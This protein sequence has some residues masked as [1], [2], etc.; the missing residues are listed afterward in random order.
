MRV[1]GLV[2]AAVWGV[3]VISAPAAA[4]EVWDSTYGVVVYEEDVGDVAVWSYDG[5]PDHPGGAIFIDG[6]AG[7]FV[8]RGEYGGFWMADGED[9]VACDQPATNVYGHQSVYW[10]YFDIQFL[11]PGFPSRWVADWSFCDGPPE[12]TWE[13]TPR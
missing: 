4:D 12:G 10:G 6:L 2:L 7:V 11:D 1:A 5:G 3:T 8:G 13:G 9:D